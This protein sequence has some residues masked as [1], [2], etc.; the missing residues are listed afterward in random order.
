MQSALSEIARQIADESLATLQH[1]AKQEHMFQSAMERSDQ[2]LYERKRELV[3]QLY[4]VHRSLQDMAHHALGPAAE[5]AQQARQTADHDR[6]REAQRE[7]FDLARQLG[8]AHPEL[9][10]REMLEL[11][12]LAR[13]QTNRL[14]KQVAQSVK[15]LKASSQLSPS[16]LNDQQRQQRQKELENAQDQF[17]RSRVNFAQE[18]LIH[19]K[20]LQRQA[21]DQLR[22]AERQVKDRQRHLEQAEKNLNKQPEN[23]SW[24][25]EVRRAETELAHA[26][27]DQQRGEDRKRSAQNVAQQRQE[28]FQ[29]AS[30]DRLPRLST[31]NKTAELAQQ[32]SHRAEQTLKEVQEIAEKIQANRRGKEQLEPTLGENQGLAT[33]QAQVQEDV[34]GVADD[35][36]RA[37][38]H[39]QRLGNQD[40]SKLLAEQAEQVQQTAETDVEQA[41][42]RLHEAGTQADLK[43]PVESRTPA[44]G[45]K[46]LAAR[47]AVH[48][49]ELAVQANVQ[50]LRNLTSSSPQGKQTDPTRE[51]SSIGNAPTNRDQQSKAKASLNK[52]RQMAQLLDELD[53]SRSSSQMDL[54][55][56]QEA[57]REIAQSLRR[58]RTATRE[59]MQISPADST[60]SGNQIGK[61]LKGTYTLIPVERDHVRWGDLRQQSAEDL[62]EGTKAQFTPEYRQMLEVYYRVL[63]E[64][65]RR[66]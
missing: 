6:L 34:A 4:E 62:R 40:A 60:E 32:L 13:S 24:K 57:S 36:A 7:A 16:D 48:Q 35:L 58:S 15:D 14:E 44:N 2:T 55:T 31:E 37:G 5:R 23:E 65:A 20:Q 59:S 42:R 43:V 30:N 41:E 26:Q 53:R 11:A 27:R 9:T 38:R 3:E 45:A 8:K 56:L 46:S 54:P 47:S 21:E 28:A 19:A 50:S 33:R 10:M 49:A 17:R 29:A 63:G 64:K 25:T 52:A 66:P 12:E 51:P 22:N 39:E 1:A 61:A 18:R